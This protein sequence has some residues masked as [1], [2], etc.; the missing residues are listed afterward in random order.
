LRIKDRINDI[1]VKHTGQP[2]EKIER[3]TDRDFYMT[4]EEAKKYGIIDEVIER[5]K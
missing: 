2:K 4:A 1:L 3:D 5:R